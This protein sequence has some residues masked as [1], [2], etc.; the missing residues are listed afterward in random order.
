MAVPGSVLQVTCALIEEGGKVL[1]AQRSDMMDLPLKWEFPGGKV[2]RGETEEDCIVRECR[3]ELNLV[4]KV[5]ERMEPSHFMQPSG[6][7]IV[8]I[9]FRCKRLSG[10]LELREH[11]AA[12]WLKV[13]SLNGLDWAPADLP[14][15]KAYMQMHAGDQR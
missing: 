15:V 1:V 4:V 3:E 14:I 7:T 9:P 2:E 6:T 10:V 11:R 8:L 5:V 12:Q 13:G